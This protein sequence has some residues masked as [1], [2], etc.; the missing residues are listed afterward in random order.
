MGVATLGAGVEVETE[1]DEFDEFW[2]LSRIGLHWLSRE[3]LNDLT[4]MSGGT[5]KQYR[6]SIGPIPG[7]RTT[8]TVL[9][10]SGIDLGLQLELPVATRLD[11][12]YYNLRS[13][14]NCS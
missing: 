10:R 12:V 3:G 14:R 2:E 4:S 1:F 13:S 5:S 7:P 11:S 8:P 9:N 6:D